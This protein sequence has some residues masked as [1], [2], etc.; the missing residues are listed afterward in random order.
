MGRHGAQGT[1][2]TEEGSGSFDGN[3][4]DDMDKLVV[5]SRALACPT[6]LGILRLI[7]DNGCSLTMAA[8]TAGLSVSTTAHHLSVLVE[9]GLAI[10]T[11]RGRESI[12]RWSR[13]RWQLVCARP[14]APTTPEE[15][16]P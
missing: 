4:M 3:R 5:I 10:K 6:R 11:V 2:I 9:A 8:H 7:G 13:N 14:P 1:V 16:T 12:Y 15:G